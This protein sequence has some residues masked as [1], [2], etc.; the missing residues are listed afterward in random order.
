M[1]DVHNDSN[2]LGMRQLGNSLSAGI[3]DSAAPQTPLPIRNKE[4]TA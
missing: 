3:A 1:H 4:K 2:D